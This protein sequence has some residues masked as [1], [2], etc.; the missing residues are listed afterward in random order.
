MT[1]TCNECGGAVRF[2]DGEMVCGK[3]G[4]VYDDQIIDYG[5]DWRSDDV[6]HDRR[7]SGPATTLMSVDKG[8]STDI[9]FQDRD[10]SGNAIPRSNAASMRRLRKIHMYTRLNNGTKKSLATAIK[11]ITQI[12]SALSLP[13]SVQ[14]DIAAEYRRFVSKNGLR[15][16]SV[17]ITV[18]S[19][20]YAVCKMQGIARTLDEISVAS[21]VDRKNLGKT[22]REIARVMKYSIRPTDPYEYV[23]RFCSKL[24]LPIDI[25]WAARGILQENSQSFVGKSPVSLAASAVYMAAERNNSHRSQRDVAKA[26]GITEMTIRKISRAMTARA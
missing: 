14:Q 9:A 1:Q 17:K 24:D 2:V 26:T 22:Y 11:D 25:A 21:G 7:H 15:G 19:L 10:A 16:R 6:R 20:T 18:A 4:L 12:C 5:P 13:E 8:L 3:C 23:E